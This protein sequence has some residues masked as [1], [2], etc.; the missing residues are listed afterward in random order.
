MEIPKAVSRKV[1]MRRYGKTV[2]SQDFKYPDGSVKD[3]LLFGRDTMVAIIFPLTEKEEVIAV[4]QFRHGAKKLILELP[5]GCQRDK[6][7]LEG[8]VQRELFGETGYAPEKIIQLGNPIWFDPASVEVSF[9]P[10]LALGCKKITEPKLDTAEIMET[11]LV[12]IREWVSMI[13]QGEVCDS[14]TITTTFLALGF[15]NKGACS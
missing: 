1:I 15:I 10:F 13:H 14:K 11:R 3:F 4:Q 5:G 2:I 8:L 7:T 9:V 6:E 12:P